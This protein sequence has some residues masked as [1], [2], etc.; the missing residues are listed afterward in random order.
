MKAITICQPYAAL[1][2]L[3]LS[4]PRYKRV[5]NR[6]WPTPH[7]GPI[8]IH[9]GKSRSWLTADED[10]PGLDVWCLNIKEM[11]F[12]AV[13]AIADMVDCVSLRQVQGAGCPEHLL[14]MRSHQHTEG[15]WC[16]VLAN[17]RPLAEPVPF[18]GA[19]KLFDVPDNIA[20]PGVRLTSIASDWLL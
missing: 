15:P 17:V 14:W 6:T 3:P 5:E 12:G 7:R 8:A 2:C 19:L 10:R 16:W 13:V 20:E 18:R 11:A 1:V 4:D 9:A